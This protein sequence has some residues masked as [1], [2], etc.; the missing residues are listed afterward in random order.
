MYYT[1]MFFL[2]EGISYTG[3]DL[4]RLDV[5]DLVGVF[6]FD[7]YDESDAPERLRGCLLVVYV[8]QALQR[9]ADLGQPLLLADATLLSTDGTA[10][11]PYCHTVI[12]PYS[13]TAIL[14]YCDTAIQ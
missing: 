10:I 9:G 8:I 5:G 1:E 4:G 3:A 11:L 6:R 7:Q 14:P 13:D 2:T 12:L